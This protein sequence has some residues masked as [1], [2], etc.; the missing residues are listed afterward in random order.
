MYVGADE[1]TD[2]AEDADEVFRCPCEK[3]SLESYLEGGCPKS[4]SISFPYLNIGMLD[5]DEKEDLTAQLLDDTSEMIA[6]FA[7]LLDE[8]CVSLERRGVSVER[9]AMRAITLGAYESENI[10]K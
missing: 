2:S 7:K 3:C 6:S 1:R 5:E 4:N 8:I 10:H 9:L